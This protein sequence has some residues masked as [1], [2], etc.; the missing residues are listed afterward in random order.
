ME[1]PSSH[2]PADAVNIQFY[3]HYIATSSKAELNM[4]RISILWLNHIQEL[5]TG[6]ANLKVGRRAEGVEY[7][8]GGDGGRVHRRDQQVAH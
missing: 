5:T 1:A 4:S 7:P 2:P 3:K 8:A 6:G